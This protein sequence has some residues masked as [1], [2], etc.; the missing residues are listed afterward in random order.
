MLKKTLRIKKE[1][2]QIYITKIK[3]LGHRDKKTSELEKKWGKIMT[4]D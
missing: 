2:E 3:G 4:V 1:I